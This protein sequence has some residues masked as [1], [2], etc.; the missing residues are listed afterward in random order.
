MTSLRGTGRTAHWAR[1][2]CRAGLASSLQVPLGIV[3]IKLVPALGTGYPLLL[4]PLLLAGPL[5]VRRLPLRDAI[6]AAVLAGLLSGAI[7]AISLALALALFADWFWALTSAAAAPPMPPLPHITLLPTE[8][9]TW[10]HQDILVF[11]PLLAL[12]LGLLT[13]LLA[14]AI[15]ALGLPIARLLPRSLTGRLRL[16]FG[17][18]VGLTLLFGGASFGMIEEMH[19]QA[20]RVQLRADWQRQLGIARTVLDDDLALRVGSAGQSATPDPAASAGRFEQV[21]RIYQTLATP[22]PHPGISAGRNDIV[23]VLRQ[24]RPLLDQARAAHQALQAPDPTGGDA[25]RETARLADAIVTLGRLQDQVNADLTAVLAS[26]DLSHHQRLIVVMALVGLIA[27]L[28]LWI[29]E[30]AL[31]TIGAPLTALGAHLSRVARGDFSRRVVAHGPNELRQLAES[32]NQ[33]SADL[34]RLY[35]VERDRRS[36]AEAVAAREHELSAAKEFWT[37]TL[38]HD[39]KSPITLISG[40][41]YL[42]ERGLHGRLSPDQADAVQQIQDAAR[43]LEDLVA[44]INDSFRLQAKALPIHRSP[45]SPDDLLL[46]AANQYRGLERPA[47]IVRTT[48]VTGPVLAD[49]RLVGRVLQN[50]IGNA[51]KHGGGSTQI[52]LAAEAG[53]N[54]VQFTVDDNGPGIAPGERERIF[55]RFTQ[56]AGAARGS[57]LGLA[58]CK[59]VI[60]QLGGRI[61]ADTSPLG[62]ARIAFELPPAHAEIPS[63]LTAADGSPHLTARV[64]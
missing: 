16:A 41:C 46:T 56:G 36:M 59:L 44:D 57:G 1:A 14:P 51:Y 9:L 31:E 30:R 54:M 63:S 3:A 22:A 21:E 40:W 45:V 58:F 48:A 17:T 32:V 61:W 28:G 7:A 8:W 25:P 47:P 64:A 34:A 13:W 53:E 2:G 35:D 15:S 10:P 26:S 50:L 11:Q 39:L 42:L 62:G 19:L 23:A 4:I 6:R 24:Y 29:S 5:A 33:M 18:L 60:Q 20:H 55:E 43:T 37:N 27:G 52:V 38:V 12:C 49:A